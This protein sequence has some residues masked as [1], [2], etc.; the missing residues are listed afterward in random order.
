[1]MQKELD[2]IGGAK[3]LELVCIRNRVVIDK[4]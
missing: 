2:L 3:L 1:M 4:E